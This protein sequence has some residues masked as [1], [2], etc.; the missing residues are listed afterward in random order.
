MIPSK[1][2]KVHQRVHHYTLSTTPKIYHYKFKEYLKGCKNANANYSQYHGFALA[3][4]PTD[5][6]MT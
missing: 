5:A 4:S 3:R 1:K 2:K 6:L